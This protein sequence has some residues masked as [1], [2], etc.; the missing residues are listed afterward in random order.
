MTVEVGQVWV[1]YGD[2]WLPDDRENPVIIISA[3]ILGIVYR[4]LDM[5]EEEHACSSEW[6]IEQF[7]E[8]FKLYKDVK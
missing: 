5:Y 7:E 2:T 4:Y 6:P 8:S 1:R 3:T